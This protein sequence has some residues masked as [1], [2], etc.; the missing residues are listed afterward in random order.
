MEESELDIVRRAY[1]KQVMAAAGVEDPRVEAAFAAVRREDFLG[2]AH[3]R[4][5]GGAG[6]LPC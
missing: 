3:G 2:P 1:A 4:S 6:M 5:G